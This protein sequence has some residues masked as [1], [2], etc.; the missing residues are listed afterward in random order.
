MKKQ[1]MVLIL[2]AIFATYGLGAAVTHPTTTELP[3]SDL[4]Q[5][6][7]GQGPPNCGTRDCITASDWKFQGQTSSQEYHYTPPQ[8]ECGAVLAGTAN[9]GSTCTWNVDGRR[10]PIINAVNSCIPQGPPQVYKIPITGTP[11]GTSIDW[12]IDKCAG[13]A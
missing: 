4:R 10:R 13:C 5:I 8:A 7:G 11:T 1:Q 9:E 2:L 6:L 12:P 3:L